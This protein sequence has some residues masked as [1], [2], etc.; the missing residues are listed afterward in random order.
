[1]TTVDVVTPYS[2]KHTSEQLL[3]RAKDSV[4][5]QSVETNHII[6]EDGEQKGPAWARNKALE[7][8]ENRFVAFLDADD[9]W[10]EDKLEKQVKHL[11]SKDKGIVITDTTSESG[12]VG[13]PSF[14]G[15]KISDQDN[16]IEQMLLGGITGVTSSIL[17]DTE[18]LDSERFDESYYRYEDHEFILRCTRKAG[19]EVLTAELTFIEKTVDGLSNNTNQIRQIQSRIRFLQEKEQGFG[20][21]FAHAFNQALAVQYRWLARERLRLGETEELVELYSK[22]VSR[23]PL[24]K[25]FGA[26]AIDLPRGVLFEK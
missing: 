14:A 3:E 16:F 13:L 17:I 18:K 20:G 23:K 9:Y 11:D 2:P 22:S 6:V 1:M 26:M 21:D 5:M 12:S 24:L 4:E 8:S 7:E 19:L 15:E 25:T 10:A